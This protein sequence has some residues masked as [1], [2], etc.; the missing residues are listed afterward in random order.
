MDSSAYIGTHKPFSSG[1]WT[2]KY[3]SQWSIKHTWLDIVITIGAQKFIFK[4][5]LKTLVFSNKNQCIPNG[6]IKKLPIT[7]TQK[8][9]RLEL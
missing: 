2:I 1:L 9:A 6:H 4:R 5:A 7:V 3:P 8:I